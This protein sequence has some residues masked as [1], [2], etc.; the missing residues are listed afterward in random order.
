MQDRDGSFLPYEHSQNI[1]LDTAASMMRHVLESHPINDMSI[2]YDRRP[3]HVVT[4]SIQSH[5]HISS[6]AFKK[7][8]E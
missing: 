7:M 3:R 8:C 5:S 1:I 4:M 2:Y 6:H